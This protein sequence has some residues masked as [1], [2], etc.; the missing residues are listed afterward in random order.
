MLDP[1]TELPDDLQPHPLALQFRPF[2]DDE[3]ADLVAD[4]T[5]NGQHLPI[6]LYEGKVLDGWHRYQAC[7]KAGV[8]AHGE[9]YT[10]SNPA[11]F[12]CSANLHRRQLNL[13]TAQKRELIA[14]VLK[15]NPDLSNR[16]IGK[17]TKTHH[18][19]VG[20]ERGEL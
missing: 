20:V 19:T 4:I 5:A 11:A 10:G 18:E 17:L 8:K 14:T 9:P 16:Q 13:T 7:I 1:I 15:E 6:M 12:V 3:F 2:T